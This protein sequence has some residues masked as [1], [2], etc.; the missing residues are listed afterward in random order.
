M[1]AAVVHCW[2]GTARGSDEYSQLEEGRSKLLLSPV[3]R[4]LGAAAEVA[5]R[6]TGRLGV[7]ARL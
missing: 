6:L 1:I 2:Q 4:G 5:K 3:L 7:G